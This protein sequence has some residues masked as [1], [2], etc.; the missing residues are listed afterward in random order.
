MSFVQLTDTHL[1]PGDS[2]LHGL[3]PRERLARGLALIERE[4]G[5]AAFVLITGDLAH[6][7]QEAAYVTLRET[8]SGLERPVHL[9]MGNHDSRAPFLRVFPDSPTIEGGFIQFSVSDGET[10]VLCL[11][12]LDDRPGEHAGRLCETR[13]R[14]LDAE[15]SKPRSEAR[16]VI[17]AHHPFFPLGLP[18]MDD[19]QLRDA[20]AFR[21]V[22][23]GR[24]PD[25]YLFGH[26]HRPISGVYGGVP[27]HTQRGF[28]HQLALHFE[29]TEHLMFISEALEFALIRPLDAGL[30]V[31]TRAVEG[32]SPAY[33]AGAENWIIPDNWP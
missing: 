26:I 20:A 2:L 22:I 12:T 5:D 33:R 25:L 23:A 13:L 6:M 11:D 9:L 7:A 10:R 29:R 31:F 15:L 27:F 17:A 16:L 4:H 21:E 14:W 3:S 28:N 24:A 8:L 30:A 1:V 19:Y 18:N 32:E